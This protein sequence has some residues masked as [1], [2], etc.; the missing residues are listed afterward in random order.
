MTN[1]TNLK[2]PLD[3]ILP[4]VDDQITQAGQL[5]FH[6]VGDTG[7]INGT[8]VQ[9]VLAAVMQSHI[10]ASRSAGKANEEPRFLYHLGDVVYYNGM[11]RHYREQFY[12]PYQGY[13]AP[14]VAIAG[15]HDG[16]T[17]IRRGDE[18]DD[19]PTLH[20]FM[21]HFCASQAQFLFKHRETMTQPYVYWTLD[22]PL[23][24]IIGL[25]SNV[26]GYMDAPGTF[27]QQRWLEQQIKDAPTDRALIIAVHHPAY[28]LD[29]AHGGYAG[30][31]GALDRAFKASARLPDLVLSGH[32]HCYQ[33]FTRTHGKHEIPYL[34][35]G[36]GGYAH[37]AGGM[38]QL[39][40][41]PAT[42]QKIRTPFQ[43]ALNG[44]KLAAYNDSEPGFLRIKVTRKQIIG[45]YFTAD[46]VGALQGVRDH[47]EI[48]LLKHKV[49]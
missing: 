38:H 17:R 5:V 26:D 3:V 37:T 34:V 11:S 19:E 8:E 2:L 29:T 6:T 21:E 28:S 20:G 18:P 40:K 30:I 43:T 24:T 44:V 27:E 14:I 25:Y 7:G 9:D 12:E 13:D 47:F 41:S 4:G 10:D 48:D 33:R 35:A 23:A 45:E 22:T 46:F 36:A 16:D 31:E 1:L 42:G 49:K 39:A 15:N 32:V